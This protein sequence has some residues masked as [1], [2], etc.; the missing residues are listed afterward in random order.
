MTQKKR[1]CVFNA[2]FTT[3][4]GDRA[5]NEAL[6]TMLVKGELELSFFPH[7][8]SFYKKVDAV[9]TFDKESR[10]SPW[11]SAASIAPQRLRY[12]LSSLLWLILVPVT[13]KRLTAAIRG[14]SVVIYGGG[15]LIQDGPASSILALD[16]FLI[17]LVGR[18][19][20][21]PVVIVGVGIAEKF[22]H[23]A[24]KFAFAFFLRSAHAVC[25]R[26]PLSLPRALVLTGSSE[27]LA[28][29]ADF[30]F[31]LDPVPVA[32]EGGFD[33]A[34]FPFASHLYDPNPDASKHASYCSAI[35]EVFEFDRQ[36]LNFPST[37]VD[38]K[39]SDTLKIP[40]VYE[41][42]VDSYRKLVIRKEGF[43]AGRM[44][45]GLFRL[46]NKRYSIFFCWDE[47]IRGVLLQFFGFSYTNFLIGPDSFDSGALR[48]MMLR[49]KDF[50]SEQSL[51]SALDYQRYLLEK[52]RSQVMGLF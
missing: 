41:D 7:R 9:S 11:R 12:C 28:V 4:V 31:S 8:F 44:H 42:D 50:E 25:V 21:V 36:A 10:T 5:I 49:V 38:A 46:V 15:Q 40:M 34:L 32:E 35:Q 20:A 14:S 6:R 37:G 29:S 30:A 52:S 1:G 33:A 24:S 16:A 43:F 39:F 26:D 51:S 18:A 13:L 19:L 3:N 23:I 48:T 27:K 45:P 2:G 22:H 17:G 47:K